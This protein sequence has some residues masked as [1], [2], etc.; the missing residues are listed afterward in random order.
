MSTESAQ[1]IFNQD[2]PAKLDG[3]ANA[4]AVNTIFQFNLDGED[5]G[6]WVVDLTKDSD[7]VTEG[8]SDSAQCTITMKT[9]DFVKLYNDKLAA[10]QAYMRGKLKVSGDFSL[11]LKLKNILG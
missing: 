1:A 7:F 11:A 10:P 5:G 8:G 2:L 3:N 6:T 4:T 9:A